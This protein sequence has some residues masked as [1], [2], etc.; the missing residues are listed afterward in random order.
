MGGYFLNLKDS[1]S[2]QEAGQCWDTEVLTSQTLTSTAI[3]GILEQGTGCDNLIP[4]RLG[5]PLPG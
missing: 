4:R 1:V 3:H 2:S 5:R